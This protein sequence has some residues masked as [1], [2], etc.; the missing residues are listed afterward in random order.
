VQ[1]SGKLATVEPTKMTALATLGV[2]EQKYTEKSA[3]FRAW[4]KVIEKCCNY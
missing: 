1:R 4:D 3:Q 2:P